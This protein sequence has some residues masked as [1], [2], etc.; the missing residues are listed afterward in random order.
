M[1]FVASLVQASRGYLIAGAAGLCLSMQAMAQ[2]VVSEIHYDPVGGASNEFVEVYNAGSNT[3]ALGNWRFTAGI[4]YLFANSTILPPGGYLVVAA[5]RTAFFT[6]Y[7]AVTNLATGSFSGQLN[8]GGE[9]LAVA[10][11]ATNVVFDVTYNNAAPW[12]AAAAG[13]GSSLVLLDPF[14]SPTNPANWGASAEL[15][16][17]PGGPGSLF[18]RDIA[19]N[20][21]LAHT[22][23]PQ[24]DAVELINVTTNAIDIAGWYLSD[25]SVERKKYRFPT[26]SVVPAGGYLVVYQDQTMNGAGALIP[27]SLSSKGDD[28]FLSQG[29]TNGDILRFVDEVAFDASKNGVSFGHYPN[30]LTGDFVPLA[31]TTFG[32]ANPSSLEDFRT[33]TGAVN[34]GPY[35]H[36]VVINEIMYNPE[37]SA[38]VLVASEFVELLNTSASPV[39]L[40]NVDFPELAW[41]LSGGIGYTFPTNLSLAPGELIVVCATNDLAGFR[42]SYNVPTNVIVLGPWTGNLNNAG[43]VLR[44]RVP[45]SPEPPSNI[46]ARYVADEVA[47]NDQLPWPIAADG[48]GGSLERI[49]PTSWGDTPENWHAAPQVATPGRTNTYFVPPG[50]VVISEIMAVNRH[51]LTDEDGDYSDWIELYNT[52]DFPVSL[53]GWH[54]T[55]LST[56][57][58]QWTFPAVSIPARGYLVVFADTK[59][60]TGDVTRL[61]T[62]FSLDEG[63]EYLGLFRSDLALEFEFDPYPAQYAD[64]GY[65]FSAFGNSSYSPVQEGTRARYLVPTNAA[66]LATNW[67]LQGFSD[68][69]WLPG[70]NGFGFDTAPDY[71]PYITTDVRAL[72]TNRASG[73]FLRFPVVVTNAG[74]YGSLE[75]RLKFEDGFI[76]WLNGV[77]VASNNVPTNAVWNSDAPSARSET[78]ALQFTSYNLTPF[79][80][81]LGNGTNI[82][83]IQCLNAGTNSSDLLMLPELRFAASGGS[84]NGMGQTLGYLSPA[85]PGTFN[86]TSL[87]SVVATPVLSNPGGL[88]AGSITV[89]ATCAE[90]AA[91]MRYTLDGSEPTAASTPYTGPLSF[92]SNTELRVRAFASGKVP[93]TVRGAMYRLSFL[94]INEFLASNATTA[95]EISDFSA[96]PDFIELFNAGTSA[97]DLAG[98][99]L[100]DSLEQPFKWPFPVGATIPAGGC[101]LVW[102]DGYDARP[103]MAMSR[104]FWP[105]AGFVTRYYHCNFKLSS[106]D[107]A[108]CLFSPNGSLVDSVS[109]GPQTVD[110]SHGRYPDG[111]TNWTYFG[112]PSAGTNNLV[113][114]L[115]H[116]LHL[117]PDVAIAPADDRLIFTSAVE[118]VLSSA[119]N[120]TEIRYTTNGAM[121]N[122]SSLLYTGSFT[123]V[124][125]G[126]VRARAYAPGL[127]P[128]PIATR[129]FLRDAR[130]PDLPML[131]LVIDPALLYNAVTGIYTNNLKEREVPGNI[132]FCT[133]PSNTGFQVNA[134]LRLYS[135]NTFLKAQKP[136]T[137]YLDSSFGD[138]ALP[139][140]LFPE[141]PVGLYDRFIL[142]NGNDDWEEAFLRDTLGQS[143]LHDV[144]DNAR[145]AYVPCAIYLNG[146]YYGLINIQ[147]KMDE[148]YC[149]KNYG[150]NLADVDFWEMNGITSTEDWILD[151][152][153]PDAWYALTGFIASNNL[154]DPTNYAIVK[155]QVDIEDLVDYAAG[156]VF[157]YDSSWF[158]NRKWWR[159]RN[160][161]GKWRWCTTDMDRSLLLGNVNHNTIST[162][163]SSLLVYKQLLANPEFRSFAA[164]RIMAHLNSS[165]STNRTLPIIDSESQRIRNEIEQHIQLYAP[166]GGIPSLAFWTNEIETIRSFARQRPAIALQ[167]VANYFSTG[168]TVRVSVDVDG[169]AGRVLANYVALNTNSPATFASGLPLTMTALPEIGQTFV[170]WEISTNITTTL[171]ATGSVWRYFDAV[172]NE[173]PGWM[174]TNFNDAAWSNGPAQLGYGDGDERTVVGFG[175][176]TNN[177]NISTY[178]R[179][180]VVIPNPAAL[181]NIQMGLMRDDGA[182]VYINGREVVRDNMPTGVVAIGT[183]ALAAVAVS[184]ESVYYPFTLSGTNFVAGTNLIAVEVHQQSTNSSDLSFDLMLTANEPSGYL[185]TTNASSFVWT[186]SHGDSIRAVYAP[187]GVSLLPTVITSNTMLTAG[188]SPYFATGDIFVPSNTTLAAGPG[189]E[190]LLPENADIRVQGQLKLL[191]STNA[192]ITI[193]P[194]TNLGAAVRYYINPDLAGTNDAKRRWGGI[195]FEHATHTGELVHVTLRGA[196]LTKSDPVNHRAAISGL[197]SDL[198]MDGLDLDDVQLP[199][200]V[201]EGDSTVL[202]NSRIHIAFVGDVINVKRAQYARIE[203]CDLSGAFTIDTD[204]ID[205][206]GM[207]G[208]II[209]GNV[210][211]DFLGDN[212]DAI[213]IG[214]G[215]IDILVESNL[216]MR[217]FDK[218]VSVGQASTAILRRNVIRDVALGVGIKDLGSYAFVEHN[219]FHK[220]GSAA[221]LYEKN[222][223][224][225]GGLA[226]IRNSIFSETALDPVS[227][228]GFSTAVVA[229]CLSDTLPVPGI[230]NVTA[231]PQFLRAAGNN[232][233]LQVG[234][235]AIDAGSPSDPLDLDGTRADMG[236]L[237]FDW[238]EGHVVVSEIHYHPADTNQSEYVELYN[239]GGTNLD[240]SGYRFA[241]GFDLTFAPGT[242]LSNGAYLVV[243][244]STNGLTGVSP[245]V[246]W[247]NGTLDNAGEIVELQDPVSNEIDRVAYESFDPW[248]SAPDGNGPSLSVINPR[249]DNAVPGNWYA[250]GGSDGTPGGPFDNQLPGPLT[251]TKGTGSVF[252]I[253][254]EALD[255][256]RYH[257]EYSPALLPPNWQT[258][259]SDTRG[260]NGRIAFGHTPGT[261]N[262]TGVY[263]I[264]IE[265]P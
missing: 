69:A 225:G 241:K 228:D 253:S 35:V 232:F 182:V 129:T 32:V 134:G 219:T 126:V 186:P 139:Y 98:Y 189:V 12:P 86:A 2:V 79:L 255:H 81:L 122:L 45:N 100:S 96:Y 107:E 124:S 235:A 220:T 109:Y 71:L 221:A 8:N 59:N 36:P 76:A 105:Y 58:T 172:T 166:R 108:V 183:L 104:P 19:I 41:S 163:G 14:S 207:A 74:N 6:R 87:P 148:M 140:K 192:P 155:S 4:T 133:T 181:A 144:T 3:V 211:H 194:N 5:D 135:Y 188:L 164:Q 234:S 226:D 223:G 218:G 151:S 161:G 138:E 21:V 157:A 184:N 42:S 102:A 115:A 94:G 55:D 44:L 150:V 193:R 49:D 136:F 246:L 141:R 53:A 185:P 199:I 97:V 213:D 30:E 200:F 68:A 31:G 90:V 191:G 63:G 83:G 159:D 65:G 257:L 85:T 82:L 131:S 13:L 75:L 70:T 106:L 176:N 51:T 38:T 222:R 143:L 18:V 40:Y 252:S 195:S 263:R 48:F 197:G 47:F 111:A 92:S 170:R 29:N 202:Q 244:A 117:S 24:E 264:R 113:P 34:V 28:L 206:D 174:A 22:D 215:A 1:R 171:I 196:S 67:T 127:H 15:H 91:T 245:L 259:Q 146:A 190:I 203:G 179:G 118:V 256:L 112:Q 93:S 77:P 239:P 230:G 210:I 101:L 56:M 37:T 46:A 50:S 137:V 147:E 187:A 103:G 254:F 11:A 27:F 233:R 43:D 258:L 248:P 251:Y 39:P 212:N 261:T 123:F 120:V 142:R 169:G 7:P 9:Q 262:N 180:S 229:Y 204:A 173:I 227:V 145:Q 84:T 61:H 80:N 99:H 208:G 16:G 216:I 224:D 153:T 62:N 242:V 165:F 201:Q 168:R 72:M 243:A 88:F 177:R 231:Q 33:G 236:A 250:S 209:R 240:L 175:G 95:P 260:T 132:Q 89:T 52:Q 214:E 198:W 54:L 23:P 237:P 178:F 121:P 156:L 265:A 116:N 154:A 64:V 130:V 217:C 25:D 205:Y 167:Q 125:S 119:T 247:T 149:V 158:H 10:D 110:I 152:G 162:M 128:G 238:R 66:M 17:S 114:G 26:N 160:P 78:L 73:L 249:R 60:R 57:A 20:E